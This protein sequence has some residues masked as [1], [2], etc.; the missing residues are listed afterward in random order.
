MV[1]DVEKLGVEAQLKVLA[2][3]E[4][5]RQVKVIP[6][7]IRAAQGVPSKASELA[8]LRI[9]VERIGDSIAIS[10]ARVHR[11]GKRIGVEPLNRAWLRAG[12]IAVS[13]IRIDAGHQACKLRPTALQNP[14]LYALAVWFGHASRVRRAE[15]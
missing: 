6:Y 9:I 8:T 10:C 2:H 4:P 12:K 14:F 1:E 7:E 11:R 15:H 13:A 5:F 3:G